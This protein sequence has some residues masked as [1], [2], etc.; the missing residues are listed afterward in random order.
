MTAEFIEWREFTS[1]Y[2]S[3]KPTRRIGR[4]WIDSGE[5]PGKIIGDRVYVDLGRFLAERENPR[6]VSPDVARLLRG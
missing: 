4:K 6:P 1:Q 3:D 2:L 5:L